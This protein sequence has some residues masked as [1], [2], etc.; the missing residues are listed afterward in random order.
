MISVRHIHLDGR[1]TLADYE[2]LRPWW[3]ARGG[4]APSREMLPTF[5]AIAERHGKPFACAFC[6]LDATGSGVG[7]LSWLATCPTSPKL[8][9]GRAL[10]L[11]IG[12]LTQEAKRLNYWLLTATYHHP[13]AISI[14]RRMGFTAAD[15]GM[16][17]LFKPI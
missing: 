2:I 10:I 5:G 3:E 6:Y 1:I 16:V 13:S 11:L 4:Q 8:L 15:R 12:F 9:S 14:L 7:M 17:Q